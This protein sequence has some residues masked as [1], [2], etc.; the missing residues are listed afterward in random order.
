MDP[1][2]MA[3]A[4]GYSPIRID[5]LATNQTPEIEHAMILN[6]VWISTT[7]HRRPS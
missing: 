4:V 5:E 7:L 1:F 2:S 6:N 3:V